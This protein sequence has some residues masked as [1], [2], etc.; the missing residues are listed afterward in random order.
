[1]SLQE[2][3]WGSSNVLLWLRIR[4]SCQAFVNATMNFRI[5]ET[6]R[7]FLTRWGTVRCSG[8]TLLRGVRCNWD[9]P[10]WSSYL[11]PWESIN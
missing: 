6:A 10:K 7:N 9:N 4:D 5:P 1:M 3:G 2:L 11:L 8:R